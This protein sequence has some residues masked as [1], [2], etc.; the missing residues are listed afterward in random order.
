MSN[1]GKYL[2]LLTKVR[3]YSTEQLYNEVFGLSYDSSS[4]PIKEEQVIACCDPE[5]HNVP[6]DPAYKAYPPLVMGVDWAFIA[7]K[8]YTFVTIGG[9]DP[10]PNKFR[11][12]YWKQYKGSEAD[13]L[14][15]IQDIIRLFRQTGCQMLAADWGAGHVQNIQLVNELGEDRVMQVWHTGMQSKG[16]AKRAVYEPK[17]RKYHLARTAVLTDTFET[18]KRRMI[19][20]PRREECD[21]LHSNIL[22]VSM[23]YNERTNRTSY[24]NIEPDDGLHSLTYCML[25]GEMLAAGGFHA[26][27][28]SPGVSRGV[29]DEL[30]PVDH[31]LYGG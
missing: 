25:A 31:A 16:T 3:D 7:E 18:F 30:W 9:W 29:D 17:T 15:Q 26:H 4:Q 10:F 23:E 6:P 8:S 21:V 1:P 12:Y 22:A 28:D 11:L 2:E 27:G 14:F 20:T 5:L 24:V 13:S 19:V